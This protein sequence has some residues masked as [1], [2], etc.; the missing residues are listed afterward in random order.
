[1]PTAHTPSTLPLR[2]VTSRSAQP[3][4]ISLLNLFSLRPHVNHFSHCFPPNSLWPGSLFLLLVCLER[5]ARGP[6]WTQTGDPTLLHP[7]Q[8]RALS[9]RME[10]QGDRSATER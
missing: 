4:V 6:G 3:D 5:R 9:Q 1:M 2:G 7:A 10:G 8:R